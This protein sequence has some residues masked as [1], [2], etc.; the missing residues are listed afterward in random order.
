M[1]NFDE[2]WR[3]YP[4]KKVAKPKCKEKYDK[5][6][7]EEHKEVMLGIQAQLR[8]RVEAKK[9]GEFMA[10]WCNS[11][12]FINQQRWY[13]EIGSH[14][15]LKEKRA[16]KECCIQGCSEPVYAPNGEVDMEGGRACEYHLVFT[17]KGKLRAKKS[18]KDKENS[19]LNV[20]DLLRKHYAEHTEIH[21]L[22]GKAALNFM[23]E[24]IGKMKIGVIK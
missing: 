24:A 12:T 23:R 11:Q 13:D 19:V 4:G 7:E 16:E 8:Y 17:P 15:E 22:R 2:F 1:N 18:Q 6:S 10:E 9:S 5:L 3:A 20:V 21:G 14:A